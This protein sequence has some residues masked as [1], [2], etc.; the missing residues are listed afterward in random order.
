MYHTTLGATP[1]QLVFGRDV[2][3][4]IRFKADW[5]AI[6]ERRQQQILRD[7]VRE[8]ATRIPHEYKVGDKVSKTR[9]GIQPKLR[10]KRDG[11]YEVIAVDDT[12]T[13]RIRQGAIAERLNIRRVMPFN[14]DTQD[15]PN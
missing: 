9:P 13:I 3:L 10:R 14:E 11:P 6:Q 5:A 8:N 1:A 2:I 7:N 15:A 12:G 4:P